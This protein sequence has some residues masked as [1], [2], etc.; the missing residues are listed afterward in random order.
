MWPNGPVCPHCGGTDRIYDLRGKS[1]RPG[2]RKC[3]HCKKPFTVTVGTVFERSHIPLHKWVQ[4][5]YLLC[6]S[7]RASAPTSSTAHPEHQLQGGLVRR[8]PHPR[9]DGVG[10]AAAFG[11]RRQDRRGRRD[12]YRAQAG[13]GDDARSITRW[14][15]C[16]S[17]SAVATFAR[18]TSK[19]TTRAVSQ[20]VKANA[21]TRSHLRTDEAKHYVYVSRE[22]ASHESVQHS[23]KE[24]VRHGDDPTAHTNTIEGFFSVFKRGMRGT[25]QHCRRKHL[26]RYLAEFDFRYNN[27][28][29][30]ASRMRSAR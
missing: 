21:D 19:A 22:F 8:A 11:R 13:R 3:G 6:C 30:S 1:T 23:G 26:H 12:V 2:V 29:T 5:L 7:K 14:R 20:I 25:Y 16:R 17:W 27:R 24:Y 28:S 9:G 15:S 4:A 18:S 10:R